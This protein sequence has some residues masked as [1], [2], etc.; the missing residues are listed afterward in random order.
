MAGGRHDLFFRARAYEYIDIDIN[1]N[2]NMSFI[3]LQPAGR[4]AGRQDD[5][6][7]SCARVY[8][9]IYIYIYIYI[10]SRARAKKKKVMAAA[11]RPGRRFTENP[12][13]SL[14]SG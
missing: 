11:G 10:Y 3:T 4:P 7:F 1:I 12:L 2:I 5:L 9:Y 13:F 6:F 14:R 8:E